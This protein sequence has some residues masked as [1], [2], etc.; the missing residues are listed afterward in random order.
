MYNGI[1]EQRPLYDDIEPHDDGSCTM[2]ITATDMQMTNYFFQF[3]QLA[4]VIS[5][6]GTR[7]RLKGWYVEA[8]EA[9]EKGPAN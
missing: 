3:R 1:V 8:N 5:P 9:Y 2:T 4:Q 6:E 7:D